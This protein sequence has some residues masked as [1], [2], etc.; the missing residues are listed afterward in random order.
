MIPIIIICY[1]NHKYVDNTIRQITAKNPNYFWNII[2]M[3]NAS[4][5]PDTIKYLGST[6]VRVF[7]NKI[8][9]GPWVNHHYNAEFFQTLPKMH[10]LTDADLQFNND[11]P[12]N[13]IDDM[14]A[15]LN[16]TNAFIVGFALKRDD[17]ELQ[18]G[19]KSVFEYE[20]PFWEKRIPH[21]TYE[22]Y[23]AG[24]DTT[25]GLRNHSGN[26][27]SVRMAGNFTA[28]HLPWYKEDNVMSIADKYALYS[29]CNKGISGAAKTVLEFIEKDYIRKDDGTFVKR[30]E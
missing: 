9:Q 4:T 23:D 1:N 22:L 27:M 24:V 30:S 21:P 5:N 6:S 14:V 3:D 10:I 19:G 11:L 8:N 13:F 12:V 18:Y 26:G 7:R 15:V 25:F 28:R 17:C 29:S 2:I 20:A 16:Y